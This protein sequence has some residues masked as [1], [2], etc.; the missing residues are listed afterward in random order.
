MARDSG[1]RRR[2]EVVSEKDTKNSDNSESE[3]KAAP[4]KTSM[5]RRWCPRLFY[6][7]R[8]LILF[9]L[10]VCILRD[11]WEYQHLLTPG[12]EQVCAEFFPA[13]QREGAACSLA[14]SPFVS[15]MDRA[16]RCVTRPGIVRACADD[17]EA[18]FRKSHHHEVL[19]PT[20]QSAQIFASLN[21]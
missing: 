1:V 7:Y 21:L 20:L 19:F 4:D 10:V 14:L 6:S 9:S 2:G 8:V 12:W 11:W 13:R 15:S 18:T 3:K 17:V 5:M 16:L